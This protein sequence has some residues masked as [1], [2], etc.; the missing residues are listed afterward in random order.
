MEYTIE[1]KWDNTNTKL[2]DVEKMF[3]EILAENKLSL[4]ETQAIFSNILWI[5][6]NNMPISMDKLKY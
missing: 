2:N 6:T 1:S 4:A 3:I 5:L